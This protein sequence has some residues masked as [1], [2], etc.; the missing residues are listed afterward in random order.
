MNDLNA[1]AEKI[2]ALAAQDVVVSAD[3]RAMEI[4]DSVSPV[5]AILREVNDTILERTLV[6]TS[7]AIT[8]HAIAAG[9]RLR[10]ILRVTPEADAEIVGQILS[11]EE[12]EAVQSAHE[13]LESL[14]GDATGMTVQVLPAEP[15]GKGGERGISAHGLAELWGVDTTQEPKPP[16]DQFLGVNAGSFKSL[17]HVRKGEIMKTS[18][19]FAK[20]QN[21]W[22]TQVQAFRE[23][24]SK[25]AKGEAGAQLICL[26]SAFDDGTSA[27]MALY[28]KDVAIIAY[29]SDHFGKMQSSWQRIFA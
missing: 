26:D 12:P 22:N 4:D 25:V 2:S 9:R 21:I 11:R 17:L 7:N 8:V 10:G 14:F 1:L 20:L 6:F 28:E 5:A 23:A 19:D 3:G 15:F 29:Q 18:G 27:A 16:M 24:H 13:L